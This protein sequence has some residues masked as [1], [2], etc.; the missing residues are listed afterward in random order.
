M[1]GGKTLIAVLATVAG[2]VAV[3]WAIRE[4]TSTPS[5]SPH[6]AVDR[7]AAADRDCCPAEGA[8]APEAGPDSGVAAVAGAGAAGSPANPEANDTAPG[9]EADAP[10]GQRRH[11]LRY[12]ADAASN[13]AGF[14][15]YA[16]AVLADLR[17]DPGTKAAL[18]RA[19]HEASAEQ[20]APLFVSV[21][22]GAAG[23]SDLQAFAARFLAKRAERERAAWTF[24][25]E[26]VTRDAAIPAAIRAE[27]AR[28]VF[29]LASAGDA[30]TLW[31]LATTGAD[32]PQVAAGIVEGLGENDLDESRA[33]LEWLAEHHPD[34]A[35]R[36][37]AGEKKAGI[38][39]L[40]GGSDP[41]CE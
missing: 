33:I 39:R 20:A 11:Y 37:A 3:G 18:L 27:A 38:H 22:R 14:F 23:D 15:E 32:E 21:L 26:Q 40:N 24:L 36:A 30:T 9:A 6:D 28:T 8:R 31:A 25:A 34:S 19:A 17:A 10:R 13:Q 1:A 29:H 41:A 7:A 5:R 2:A 4:P 16:P 35:L 12:K